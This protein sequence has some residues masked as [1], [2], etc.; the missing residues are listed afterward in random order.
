[1]TRKTGGERI[2][3]AGRTLGFDLLDFWQWADSDLISNALRGRFAEYLVARALGI[4]D[5]AVRNEWD[6]FDLQSREGT[7]I[8]VKSA[9]YVQTWAQKKE[10]LIRFGIRP[11]HGVDGGNIMVSLERARQ[12]DVYVFALLHHRERST[13]DALD[14]AHWEF[15][16]LASSV[17]N[18]HCPTQKG[19]ALSSLLKLAPTKATFA[20][21][22]STIIR[23]A[24]GRA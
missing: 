22:A 7:K 10:S 8:E 18:A 3:D 20:D 13:I 16:V 11:T 12:A 15:Y 24:A 17:L 21:L 9:A 1:M 2:H 14:V 4:A 6:S 5:G 19:I 23:V